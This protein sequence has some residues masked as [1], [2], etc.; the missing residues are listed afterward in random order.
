LRGWGKDEKRAVFQS[1]N[2]TVLAAAL[3]AHTA[4]GLVTA[5]VCW[6]VL[7]ALPGTTIGAW[8]GARAYRRL[9]DRRFHE[10]VLVL[11]LASGAVLVWNALGA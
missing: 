4:S 3:L 6:L 5:E 7:L 9:S 1:F 11:L 2:L 10:V 8:L